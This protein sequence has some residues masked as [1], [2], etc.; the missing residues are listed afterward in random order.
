MIYRFDDFELD[1]ARIELRK[2]GKPLAIEPQV[3]AV[4]RLLIENRE[5]MVS[6]DEILE[7]VWNGRVV[8]ESAMSS[9]IKSLRRLLGDTGDKQ[10]FIRTI[11]GRG[12]RFVARV[13]LPLPEIEDSAQCISSLKQ[14]TGNHGTVA[15]PE[16]KADGVSGQNY[17]DARPALAVLPF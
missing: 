11:R 5:R 2:S 10:E 3:F 7:Q 17:E 1:L 15:E 16:E 12:F 13:D 6:K 4:L 8:S 14:S 9:R